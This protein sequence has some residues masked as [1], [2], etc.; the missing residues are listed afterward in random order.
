MNYSL[1]WRTWIVCVLLLLSGLALA[2]DVYWNNA[3]DGNWND[4][5]NWSTGNV[6]AA[7][8]NVFIDLAGDYTVTLD[9][10]ITVL[11]LEVGAASGT[12]TLAAAGRTITLTNGGTVNGNGV[13]SLSATTVNSAVTLNNNGTIYLLNSNNIAAAL[14]NAGTISAQNAGNQIT[15][16]LTTLSNSV[17]EISITTFAHVNLTVANGFTNNGII[18]FTNTYSN[19]NLNSVL[20]VSSGSLVNAAGATIEQVATAGNP[21]LNAALDNQGTFLLSG[22]RDLTLTSPGGDHIN[23]GAITV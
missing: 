15:G 5:G 18:R 13:L 10:D 22:N 4:A 12:Q 14:S 19:N 21:T 9:V 23:T 6:P 1:E 2:D 17:I 16:P 7:G 11:S 20:T 3:A 8:D